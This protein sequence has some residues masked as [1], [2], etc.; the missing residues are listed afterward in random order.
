MAD[1]LQ[2][3]GKK[4]SRVRKRGLGKDLRGEEYI[5]FRVGEKGVRIAQLSKR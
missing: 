4:V 3:E 1:H 2:L 5:R